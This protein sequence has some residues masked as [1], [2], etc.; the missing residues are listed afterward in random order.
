MSLPGAFWHKICEP[1]DGYL[2]HRD[3]YN[4]LIRATLRNQILACG[5]LL[6]LGVALYAAFPWIFWFGAGMLC[7]TWIFWSWA[8]FF[9]RA[10]LA[11]YNAAFLKAILLRF[12]A[13]LGLLAALLYLAL[14]WAQ[15]PASAILAGLIAGAFIALLSYG[16]NVLILGRQ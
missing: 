9:L 2:W 12:F 5:F 11:E 15:A 13:R 14:A 8:R 3:I 7:M 16:Y 6:L 4:H 1:L 10:N